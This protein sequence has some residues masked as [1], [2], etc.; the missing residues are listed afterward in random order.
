MNLVQFSA[1][2]DSSDAST[3]EAIARNVAGLP[4]PDGDLSSIAL[5][6]NVTDDVQAFT[7]PAIVSFQGSRSL[8][9]SA[10]NAAIGAASGP[11]VAAALKEQ[12]VRLT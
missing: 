8:L 4:D 2:D 1:F 7:T 12:R 5:P 11:L 10:L 9:L 3:A 6:G